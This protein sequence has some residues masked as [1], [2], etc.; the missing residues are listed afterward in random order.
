MKSK[1]FLVFVLFNL[2]R[3]FPNKKEAHFYG[4]CGLIKDL[5]DL[6]ST[7]L[8]YRLDKVSFCI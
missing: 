7:G 5:I 3:K 2:K 6:L 1:Q 4:G 8:I